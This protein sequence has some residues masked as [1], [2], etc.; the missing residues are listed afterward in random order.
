MQKAP[1]RSMGW[2]DLEKGM[3]TLFS[4]LARSIPIDGGAGQATVYGV[5]KSWT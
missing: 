2:E 1:A 3:A 5:A 4:V